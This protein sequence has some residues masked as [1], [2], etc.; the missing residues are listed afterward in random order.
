[1]PSATRKTTV[2][3]VLGFQIVWLACA[4]GASRGLASPGVIAAVLFVGGMIMAKRPAAIVA[5][6]AVA[7]AAMGLMAESLLVLSGALVYSAPWPAAQFA[8]AWI[9]A[10][11][12][13][14]GA[15]V[16]TMMQLLG[17]HR[18]LLAPVLGGVSGPLSYLAGE[19]LGA[20]EIHMPVWQVYLAISC[21]WAFALPAL[22]ELSRRAALWP[23]AETRKNAF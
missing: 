22:L 23:S 3:E 6:T 5:T 12:A 8:P 2:L 20:L 11:W 15:T 13:A 18:R 14:F 7:S 10:L 19:R 9:V 1:M 21:L 17:S 4:L 16:P